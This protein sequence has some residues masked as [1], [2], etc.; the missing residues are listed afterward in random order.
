MNIFFFGYTS[1]AAKSLKKAFEKKKNIIY[2]S[3]KKMAKNLVFDLKKKNNKLPNGN[4]LKNDQTIREME[5]DN[6]FGPMVTNIMGN[7]VKESEM[8]MEHTLTLTVIF[9]KECG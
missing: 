5:T 6:S 7:T 3:R 2:F 1:F 9:M 8:D 4:K